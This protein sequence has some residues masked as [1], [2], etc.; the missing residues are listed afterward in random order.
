MSRWQLG[1]AGTAAYERYLVPAFFARFA[2]RLIELAAPARGDRVVDVACGTGIV[3]R[4]VARRVGDT[5]TIVGLDTN[6]RMLEVARDATAG[7]DPPIRWLAADATEIPLADESADCVLCQQGLQFFA[8]RPA[9]L[10]EMRR[11][12]VPDGRL[13]LSVWRPIE[14]NPGFELLVG[15]LD[16]HAGPEVGSIMRAPFSGPRADELVDLVTTAGMRDVRLHIRVAEVRFPSPGDFLL[17]QAAASP[18]GGPVAA[19]TDEVRGAL[20]R[21]LTKA[22]R[23][24]TDADG[25][26]FPLETHMVTAVR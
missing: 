11:I 19:L 12:L 16:R 15:E 5:G 8:D 25:V 1:G 23:S 26:V 20:A 21:G 14:H 24:Y 22:L 13:A 17:Q 9:A 6:E 18:L 2:K 7:I 4:Q 3:A 10:R